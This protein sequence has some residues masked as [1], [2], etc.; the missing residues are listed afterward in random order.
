MENETMTS[1][2]PGRT[3]MNLLRQRRWLLLVAVGM[4]LVLGLAPLYLAPAVLALLAPLVPPVNDV[5]LPDAG[6]VLT[7]DP[8]ATRGPVLLICIDALRPDHLP[9]YGYA[10]PTAPGLAALA[11]ES[12]LFEQAF[13]A[14]P[15]S[16]PGNASLLSGCWPARHG[17]FLSLQTAVNAR[18]PW[19]PSALQAAGYTTAGV[20][21]GGQVG[22][23]WGFRRGFDS[24]YE[25]PDPIAAQVDRVIA[26]CEATQGDT[27]FM[28]LHTYQTHAPLQPPPADRVFTDPRYAGPYRDGFSPAVLARLND[29]LADAPALAPA[30][31]A[32]MVDLYDESIHAV[33]RELQRLWQYL[34]RRGQLRQALI[35]IT[36]DHGEEFG[37]HGHWGWHS[38]SLHDEL[39]RV[40]LLVHLPG[41]AAG[42]RRIALPA[43]TVDIFPTV[44]AVLSL[45]VPAAD[46]AALTEL[47]DTAA[48]PRTVIAQMDNLDPG[49]RRVSLFPTTCLRT[50]T[51]KTIVHN[52]MNN[53]LHALARL[54]FGAVFARH[55]HSVYFTRGERYDLERD[56]GEMQPLREGLLSRSAACSA[57]LSPFLIPVALDP[58]R[59]DA[60]SRQVI[61]G[62]GYIR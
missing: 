8:P 12:V 48:R 24:F 45:P 6:S 25:S 60:A 61:R 35:I 14:S 49:Y 16:L 30:D 1:S 52:E 34:A 57:I 54:P 55:P 4:V 9:M 7:A 15:S 18:V 43:R 2:V 33:D 58:A 46:G 38:H 36:A 37:E 3:G 44:T 42:G 20:V 50:G 39:L 17:A 5:H 28:F 51:D 53:Y 10:R 22:A 32:H 31:A 59:P 23:G 21:G 27:W 62:L 26:F 13:T 40:P 47:L 19:L 56:P 41:H 11:A 29:G